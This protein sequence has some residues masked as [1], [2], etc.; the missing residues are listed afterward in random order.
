[1]HMAVSCATA[2]VEADNWEIGGLF[3]TTCVFAGLTAYGIFAENKG[4]IFYSAVCT[5]VSLSA[6]AYAIIKRTSQYRDMQIGDLE[7]QVVLDGKAQPQASRTQEVASR[8]IPAANAV[9]L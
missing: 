1:M 5:T 7:N 4:L 8:T 3:A 9:A 6:T 2:I